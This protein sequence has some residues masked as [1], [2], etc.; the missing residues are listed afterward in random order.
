M[1]KRILL[2]VI[3]VISIFIIL[4]LPQKTE[5][6]CGNGICE[7]VETTGK[8][9]QDCN[10]DSVNFNPGRV[11]HLK[12]DNYDRKY[13]VHLPPEYNKTKQLPVVLVLHGGHGNGKASAR[14]NEF[15][16]LADKEGFIAVF[17]EA[18]PGPKIS[19][20]LRYQHWNGGPRTNL[21][22]CRDIDDVKFISLMIDQL[23]TN[24]NIDN[25]KVYATGI[26]NG[27]TMAYR[28]ACELSDKIA[29]IA[30]VGANQLDIKCTP[31]K[32]VAIFH[33]HG[34]KDKILPYQGGKVSDDTEDWRP[35]NEVITEWI[36][37]NECSENSVIVEEDKEKI[38]HTYA[39]CKNNSTIK[40][41]ALK[42]HG[43]TWPGGTYNGAKSCKLRP[44]G[45]ICKMWK[46]FVGPIQMY[47]ANEEI[48]SFFKKHS[49]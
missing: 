29:A 48:W 19:S 16:K 31:L 8:C 35:V 34:L 33:I 40:L 30:P 38:C 17:P 4:L 3:I 41:C 9:E 12:V 5:C 26:S 25:K 27:G 1:N 37:R 21:H 7:P 28:L 6:S 39:D 20:N 36:K 43:H 22:K 24:Y 42:K 47:S 45:I 49:L 32:P 11:H 14:Q 2:L 23:K 44:D 46:D 15:Y 10:S 18:F 13:Y